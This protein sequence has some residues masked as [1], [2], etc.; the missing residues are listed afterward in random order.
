MKQYVLVFY[1][2]LIAVLSHAQQSNTSVLDRKW[3]VGLYYPISLGEKDK[4]FINFN[5]VNGFVGLNVGYHF[6][7][8]ETFG[9]SANY[10]L[11]FLKQSWDLR[12]S[13]FFLDENDRIIE[14]TN[15]L[16]YHHLGLLLAFQPQALGKF[17]ILLGLGY[18]YKIEN[19]SEIRYIENNMERSWQD[20]FYHG[21]NTRLGV[22]YDLTD[23]FYFN[24]SY[25]L[26]G[27]FYDDYFNDYDL[28]FNHLAKI[29]GGIR[30]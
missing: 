16:F 23:V 18:T 11:D 8:N 1:F 9:L 17:S 26:I 15:S 29:G 3:N 12:Y 14:D 21:F 24:A 20:Q 2:G 19:K 28:Y 25:Q 22:I 6:Y 5:G 30:F 4:E 7:Q 13:E 10:E 27:T